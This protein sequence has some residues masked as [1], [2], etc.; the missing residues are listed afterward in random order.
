MIEHHSVAEAAV[1]GIADELTGQAVNAFVALKNGD[2]NNDQIKK[3]LV[4]QVRKRYV[5]VPYPVSKIIQ[6]NFVM[7]IKVSVL[8]PLLNSSTSF[9]IYQRQEVARSC[10]VSCERL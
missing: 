6:A 8:S 9:P 2:D 10:V 7:I 5:L 3:D 1:V 4:L